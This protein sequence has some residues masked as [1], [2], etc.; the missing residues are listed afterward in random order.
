MQAAP[1]LFVYL[2]GVS[3]WFIDKL[4][5]KAC[6]RQTGSGTFTFDFVYDLAQY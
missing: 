4:N 2:L 5:N 1:S 6:H 3:N